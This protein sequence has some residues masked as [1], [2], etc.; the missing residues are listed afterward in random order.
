MEDVKYSEKDRKRQVT[1][2][3]DAEDYKRIRRKKS[4]DNTI[5]KHRIDPLFSV[6][7]STPIQQKT[8]EA[9]ERMPLLLSQ[10]DS[11]SPHSKTQALNQLVKQS[12]TSTL[13]F[14]NSLVLPILKRDFLSSLPHELA[15][16]VISYLDVS[17]LCRASTVCRRWDSIIS[18]DEK[19]WLRL[20]DND[21]FKSELND[22]YK[23]S[24]N[25]SSHHKEIYK[26]QHI[27]K[28][29][30]KKGR[31]KK[32]VFSG[33]ED[34]TVTC[35]QFDQDKIVS[36]ASD[37]FINVYDT[38]NPSKVYQ[39]E[40][41]QGGVWA[42]QYVDNT[43]VS[44]STDRTVRVWN[45]KK[46]K[47]THVFKGHSSTV[48]CLSIVLPTMVF[49]VLE[50]SE[51]L[52]V[53]GSRDSTIRVWRLPDTENGE[54]FRGEEEDNKWFKFLL[55]GHTESVRSIA[56]HGNTLVSGSYDNSVAIWNLES[57]RLVHRMERHSG[58]VYAVAIDPIRQH[59]MSGSMDCTVYIW[60]IL[61]GECLYKLDGHSVLVGLLGSSPHHLVSAAADKTLR[62]WNPDTGVCEHVLAGLRGHN[63][64]ITC[65]KHDDEK[66]I[67]GSEGGLKMWD[68]KTG[69]HLYNLIN[70]VKGVWWVTFD[71]RRCIAAVNDN[72]KTSFVML[73]FGVYGLEEA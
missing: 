19:T 65:F 72:E 9:L 18:R 50:P 34:H 60:D 46:R 11:L 49:G 21:G 62:V 58:Y 6:S 4:L 47:C 55:L 43:L 3:T 73:D 54:E 40:G 36:S 52:I 16:Q 13:Q 32:T 1:T 33:H 61:T 69:R 37:T 22:N 53:T 26:R 27:L 59:C 63:S 12:N 17:S 41:H 2:F 30:W 70:N 44:G 57:G 23:N 39:L 20:L 35:L 67:S 5:F 66:V 8:L 29:N 14:I 56:A 7:S 10:F 48:R 45:I 31:F 24:N 38:Q 64:A 51:P 15:L 42:L 25:N 68:I 28:T 71:Y